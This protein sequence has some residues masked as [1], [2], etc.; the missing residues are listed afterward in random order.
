MKRM[1]K[2]T[3][4]EFI[5]ALKEVNI[6]V[7]FGTFLSALASKIRGKDYT[8]EGLPVELEEEFDNFTIASK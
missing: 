1:E 8:I 5:A 4:I 7:H 3:T 6:E 2:D